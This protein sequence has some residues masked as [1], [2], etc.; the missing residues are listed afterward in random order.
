[1]KESTTNSFALGAVAATIVIIIF[2]GIG[3][4]GRY[5][6]QSAQD[7]VD[8]YDSCS[9]TLSDYEDALVEANDNIDEANYMI[10]DA[11]SYAWQNYYDM[12]YALENLSTID[13]V[14]EP[15]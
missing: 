1:M 9:S 12:G 7:W 8:D 15:Y 2:W 10:E 11:Q 4:G 3:G 5:E 13:N 6:G 14:S